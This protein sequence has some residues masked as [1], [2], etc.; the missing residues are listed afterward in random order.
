VALGFAVPFSNVEPIRKTDISGPAGTTGCDSRTD[1]IDVYNALGAKVAT[2]SQNIFWCYNGSTITSKTRTRTGTVYGPLYQFN[3]HI[4]NVESGGVG[5][6][7]YSAWTQGSFCEIAP[8]FGCVWNFYP[9]VDQTVY[10]TG[11]SWG[12][13]GW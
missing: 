4:G 5:Q 7:S 8:G 2:Y 10:G 9:W 11:A 6:G 1:G 13:A 12:N 3:G